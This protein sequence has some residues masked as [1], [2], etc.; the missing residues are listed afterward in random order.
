MITAKIKINRRG[1]KL[2]CNL[3]LLAGFVLKSE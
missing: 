3:Y 2:T 1:L